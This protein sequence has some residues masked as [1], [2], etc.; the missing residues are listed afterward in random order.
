MR[1]IK[2]NWEGGKYLYDVFLKKSCIV[3]L[4][5]QAITVKHNRQLRNLTVEGNLIGPFY[6]GVM[7]DLDSREMVR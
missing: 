1:Y 6:D 5:G 4:D 7:F 2:K 3:E